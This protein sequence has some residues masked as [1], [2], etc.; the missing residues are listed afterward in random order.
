MQRFSVLA[1]MMVVLWMGSDVLS[2]AETSRGQSAWYMSASNPPAVVCDGDASEPLAF[3]ASELRRYLGQILGMDVPDMPRDAGAP[4]IRLAVASDAGWNDEEYEFRAE[5]NVY[6]ITGGGPAGVVYGT[7]EFLRRFGGCRFSDLGPDGEH[8]PPKDTI[9]AAAGPI[10]VAPKLWYRGLQFS[11][12]EDP[13]LCRQRIDWMAKNGMNYVMIKPAPED[14]DPQSTVTVDPATGEVRLPERREVYWNFTH[15]WFDK[16]LR[17]EVRRRG[18]KLDMNHHNLLYWLPPRRYLVEHPDWYAEVDGQRGKSFKQLCICTTNP[19]AIQTLIENIRAYLRA[20]PDVKVVGVIPEDHM[21][22]CQCARCVAADPD[23]QDAFRATSWATG[24]RS[25]SFRYGKLLGAVAN[26][27]GEEFPEVRVG[28][29]AYH[30]LLWPPRDATYPAQSV[31]WLAVHMRD[32]CRPL[33]E[34]DTSETNRKI[35]DLIKQWKAIYQGRLILYEYYMGM[36]HHR[37]LPYA[38]SEV[39][40]EDWRHLKRLGVEGAT[41]Q[42]WSTNHSAYGLNNLA[43]ARCGWSDE[44]DHAEILDEYLQGTFGAAGEPLRP[45]FQG[46]VQAV[47]KLAG[48]KQDMRPGPAVGNQLLAAVGC[49]AIDRAVE[50]ARSAATDDRQRR[51][52]AKLSA[53]VRYWKAAADMIDL[54]GQA[55]RAARSDP[56]AAAALLDDLLQRRWPEFEKTM[57]WSQ[58]RGWISIT[59]PDQWTST[60]ARAESLRAELP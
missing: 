15:S 10:R 43:F 16:V 46:M 44:V 1:T 33:A 8:V 4:I 41:V 53:A 35:V 30:D 9:E 27:I 39:I 37:S 22:M 24:N 17:P 49:D 20:N 18:L 50:A 29:E 56:K 38:M 52:V 19:D 51:Q 23:P 3:A 40:C 31:V 58:A 54:Q 36:N 55:E 48:G 26:A 45:I 42:C 60:R 28:G 5:G 21:G 11:F 12:Y 25:K 34:A 2:L 47:G 14:A 6:R 59:V 57:Q 32:G 13:E 7:Y